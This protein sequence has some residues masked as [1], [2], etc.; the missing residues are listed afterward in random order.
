M[1]WK[2]ILVE[3]M[4]KKDAC[5]IYSQIYT[6]I[7]SKLMNVIWKEVE[8]H[9]ENVSMNALDGEAKRG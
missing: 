7:K 8:I 2:C 9:G 5:Y 4:F 3:D 1:Q 6:C